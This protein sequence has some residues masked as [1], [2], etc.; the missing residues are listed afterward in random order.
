MRPARI[1]IEIEELVLDG[2]PAVEGAAVAT[3]IE[4]ALS[5]RLWGIR[6]DGVPVE[7][8]TGSSSRTIGVAVA[9]RLHESVLA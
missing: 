3:E 1:E 4:R 5:A 6:V 9:E 8:R 2:F 7:A